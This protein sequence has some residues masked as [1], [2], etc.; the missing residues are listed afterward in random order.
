ML[1]TWISKIINFGTDKPGLDSYEKHT[2]RLINRICFFIIPF[3][4]LGDLITANIISWT[5]ML[6]TV[7]NNTGFALVL[8]FNYKQKSNTAKWL[9]L[10]LLMVILCAVPFLVPHSL[11]A[12]GLYLALIVLAGAV[13]NNTKPFIWVSF[14]ITSLLIGWH[15]AD[16]YA[17]LHPLNTFKPEDT[18]TMEIVY[19]IVIV[20][21]LMIAL[22]SFQKTA[23]EY[24]NELSQNLTQKDI[25][26]KEIHH[27]VK[28]NL[29]IVVSMLSLETDTVKSPEAIEVISDIKARVVSMSIIH[30]KLYQ[31]NG[32][33]G[34]DLQ[35]YLTELTELLIEMYS[36]KVNT[37]QKTIKLEKQIIGLDLS[38][39]LG[40]MVTELISNSIK[41]GFLPNKQTR[42][43][44]VGGHTEDTTGYV[45]KIKDNGIGID[46]S[47]PI[48]ENMGFLLIKILSKQ[49]KAK[50]ERYN[51]E[52][53]VTTITFKI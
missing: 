33:N 11:N 36:S 22:L 42:I 16:Y 8:Y 43:D 24:Q 23:S 12:D 25:L 51:E 19:T 21:V 1:L 38:I 45:L 30:N 52:G 17:L 27:R 49:I 13:L 10:I 5:L 50:V 6:D 31:D 18:L 34:V 48:K 32:F 9:F 14:F 46:E 26:I 28:N 4:F 40:L 53:L 47:T 39:P 20:A 35:E 7:L 29:Q 2:I 37:V 44:I 3:N 41:Y 15:I